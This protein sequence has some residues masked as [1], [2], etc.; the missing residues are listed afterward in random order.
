[1]ALIDQR[2]RAILTVLGAQH[3]SVGEDGGGGMNLLEGK[4]DMQAFYAER[5]NT[6]IE[7]MFNNN[8]FPQLMR[9]NEWVVSKEDMPE[10]VS[11]E[12]QPV[13]LDER[14]KFINRVAR[15]LPA[16]PE[17]M[18]NI[19]EAMGVESRVSET[20]TADELR[21][22]LFEFKEPSKVGSGEGSSGTGITV[23]GNSDTNSENAA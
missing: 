2:R 21:D 14:G 15:L 9:I 1:M 7:E 13:S 22:M 23:Q 5:D 4:S 18:N 19:L 12:I 17:V 16:I 20:A 3:L 11:G 10:W 6:I 8:I